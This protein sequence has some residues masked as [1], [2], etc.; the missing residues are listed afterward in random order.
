ML[1]EKQYKLNKGHTSISIALHSCT[2]IY[3][4]WISEAER[5]NS[6][7][8]PNGFAQTLVAK[9]QHVD[10]LPCC[11]VV[12]ASKQPIAQLEYDSTNHHLIH[13]TSFYVGR[14][15]FVSVRFNHDDEIVKKIAAFGEISESKDEG[16]VWTI[17]I[18]LT[19]FKVCLL[20][21][22]FQTDHATSLSHPT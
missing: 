11:A 2:G 1:V 12:S 18:F 19:S 22:T 13:L 15:S 16:F 7:S 5:L 8:M 20:F 6:A 3:F 14:N 21:I 17:V 9:L 4:V 10:S